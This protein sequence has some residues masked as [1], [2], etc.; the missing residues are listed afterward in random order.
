MKIFE[1]QDDLRASHG[2]HISASHRWGLPGVR[3]SG[4]NEIWAASGIDYPP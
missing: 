1:L 2:R 4:C 3:C